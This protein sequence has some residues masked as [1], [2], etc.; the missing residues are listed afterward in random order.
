[1]FKLQIMTVVGL[2]NVIKDDKLIKEF[3]QG[4]ILRLGEKELRRAGTVD[5]NGIRTKLRSVGRVL[6]AAKDIDQA[7][8]S[9]DDMLLHQIMTL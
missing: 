3:A 2:I 4:Q 5:I 7:I 6:L 1:M 8:K 9:V